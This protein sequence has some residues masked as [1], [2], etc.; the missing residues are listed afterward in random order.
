MA[1]P[2]IDSPTRDDIS[3]YLP[4]PEDR[5]QIETVAQ[6]LDVVSNME[7]EGKKR[8]EAAIKA[9]GRGY[10][11]VSDIGNESMEPLLTEIAESF[12]QELKRMNTEAGKSAAG[13]AQNPS[14]A[15]TAQVPS[16]A[17]PPSNTAAQD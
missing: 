17:K 6:M 12:L 15:N 7:G 10:K 8:Y 3:T 14:L 4:D 2:S 5:F 11:G 9:G 1:E 13:T 16:T